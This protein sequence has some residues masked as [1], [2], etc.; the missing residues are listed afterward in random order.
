MQSFCIYKKHTSVAAYHVIN[1][2]I[3]FLQF[4]HSMYIQKAYK[5]SFS[6]L[7]V[8]VLQFVYCLYVQKTYKSSFSWHTIK[9]GIPKHGTTNTGGTL[10]HH[11]NTDETPEHWRNNETLEE[12]SEYH[13]IAEQK[14]NKTTPRNTTNTE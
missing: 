12:Q 2:C 11:R 6:Y 1:I 4:V 9:P 13:R 8:Q 14:S 3:H 10:A 7:V 5:D